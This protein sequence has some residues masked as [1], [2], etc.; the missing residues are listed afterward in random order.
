M[1]SDDTGHRRRP[2]PVD[3][4]KRSQ[5]F[6]S[7]IFTNQEEPLLN[8][9]DIT[10]GWF[11]F[12]SQAIPLKRITIAEDKKSYI[13]HYNSLLLLSWLH[14]A[15]PPSRLFYRRAVLTDLKLSDVLQ[16]RMEGK[17]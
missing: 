11:N 7:H 1:F 14:H 6:Q 13:S 5:H 4:R 12:F 10:K 16:N 8:L 9:Y 15:E 3:L 2:V 17:T